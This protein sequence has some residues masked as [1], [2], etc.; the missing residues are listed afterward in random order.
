LPE[1]QADTVCRQMATLNRAAA[2][3]LRPFTILACTDVTG[4]GL[5]GHLLEMTR[6]SGVNAEIIASAIPFLPG[7]ADLIAAGSVP[8]GT[9]N[10]LAYVAEWIEWPTTFAENQKLAVCDAQ[11]SGGLLA[12]VPEDQADQ[13]LEALRQNGV[14]TAT[15]IGRITDN[16]SGKIIVID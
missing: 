7:V 11:T 6:G 15:V 13:A 4:F 3:A 8:G 14:A 5:A 9:K 1:E 10:N 2:D 16:G 12:A